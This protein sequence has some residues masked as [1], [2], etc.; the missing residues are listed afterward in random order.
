MRIAL[1]SPTLSGGGAE[2]VAA[3]L[4]NDWAT[5]GQSVTVISFEAP[6]TSPG[7]PLEARVS[8]RQI[9]GLNQDN[10]NVARVVT[11]LRRLARLRRLLK[12]IDADVVVAFTTEANVV[13]LLATRGLGLSVAV[14]E[15]NQPDRPGL[16]RMRR[17]ARR[18]TYPFA[19][20]IVMQTQEIALWAR[21]RFKVPVH[22]L[23]NPVRLEEIFERSPDNVVD[24]RGIVAAG[25]LVPQKGF[26][27]LIAAFAKIAQQ[28][29]DW[30]M[31]IYGE[32]PSRSDLEAQVREAGLQS[33]VSLPGFVNEIDA[34]LQSAGLFV[35]PSRYE[36]F[37]NILLEAL[38]AS[39]P[40]VAA[41]C[42]GSVGA[43]LG[44]DEFGMLVPAE[45][46][47]ALAAALGQMMSRPELRE[48]YASKAR[49]AVERLDAAAIGD[50]WLEVFEETR[51]SKPRGSLSS[52]G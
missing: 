33:R 35:L 41:N 24:Q 52:D 8:L 31:T 29:S 23:P 32:G 39:C 36:G 10:G 20:A 6:G 9:D 47:E 25:R 44:D 13:T 26:D 19:D 37:P 15:R 14:C 11:N 7:Y 12:E 4:S 49:R 22:V 18:L 45:D 27:I 1:I 30:F 43:I 38:A 51:R 48:H 2:R 42:P 5:K 40:A 17:A 34:A 28:H 46:A 21:Q 3:V 16:G 50:R